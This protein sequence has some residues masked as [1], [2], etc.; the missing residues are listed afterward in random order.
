MN[1][2]TQAKILE[3]TS[4][5]PPRAGWGVR[6][7]HVKKRLEEMGHQCLVL[8]TGKSRKIKS[9]D[10]L[11]VQNGADYAWK[12]LS[13]SLKGY[14]V[15]MHMNGDSPKGFVLTLL[16]E[17]INLCCGKRC[18][19]TFHAGPEQ[20]YFPK[21]RSRLLIPLFSLIF[22]IPKIIICNSPAVKQNIITYG[23]R[24]DKIVPIPAFSKQ[25]LRYHPTMVSEQVERFFQTHDIVVSSYVFFR[26]EFF[27]RSLIDA[28]G[29]LVR[30][31]PEF[32]LIIMGSDLEA[33]D[34][35]THIRTQGLQDHI[36]LTGDLCHDEFLTIMTRSNIFVRTPK[37]DGVCSSVL[38][39]LSL[40]VPVVASD[41]GAR[42]PSVITFVPDDAADLA[43][44]I[45]LTLDHYDE[46][47]RAIV[48][49]DIRDTVSE[50]AMIL[51]N[52]KPGNA[53]SA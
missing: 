48:V 13:F 38:E 7:Q 49:P 14:T 5:P 51:V 47:K 4:Y 19:L 23:A 39:A 27:I 20:C 37:K 46:A 43:K 36:V 22:L 44:Q 50:E 28:V 32:G 53:A 42:P 26:P 24:A 10:Y 34:M 29:L 25:Y 33:Q 52:S 8:N 1:D 45:T 17:L 35:I 16:S 15:H 40:G 11:D 6:V 41:N 12:V 9:P 2:T 30:R 21:H 3:I 18:Y 31:F